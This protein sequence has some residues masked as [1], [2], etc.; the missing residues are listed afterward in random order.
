ME[1]AQADAF[2]VGT[3]LLEGLA[4]PERGQFI[5]TILDF[6]RLEYA[7]ESEDYTCLI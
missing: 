7:I 5:S 3:P 6:F 4:P 2:W 1:I